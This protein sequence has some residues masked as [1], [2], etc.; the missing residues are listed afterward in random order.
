MGVSPK[1]AKSNMTE[2]KI[3]ELLGIRAFR[4]A[5]MSFERLRHKKDGRRNANYH[6]KNHSLSAARSF[7]WY[8]IYNSIF[9]VLSLLLAA[10]Y[11]V[12]TR[13]F[14]E[15]FLAADIVISVLIVFNVYC[16]MLQRYT[17]IRLKEHIKLLERRRN[18]KTS[19]T[20][21]LLEDTVSERAE[22]QAAAEFNLI[23][24][25]LHA[26]ANGEDLMLSTDDVPALLGIS[27]VMSNARKHKE[28]SDRSFADEGEF[29]TILSELPARV[30]VTDK[31]ERRVSAMQ[32]IIGVPRRQNVLFTFS[33]TTQEA[34]C[35]R[36]Y[37]DIFSRADRDE[38]DV[39]LDSL[40]RAYNKRM[41]RGGGDG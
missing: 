37:V 8:V 16:L 27:E 32:K 24:K 35:E 20:S 36:I 30:Y 22:T 9:H 6:L 41:G 11:F 3:Y 25:M 5:I 14:G 29:D 31:T 15:I 33:V 40:Y 21:S 38:V 34:E 10:V 2:R 13:V 1:N 18:R 12:I 17:W 4:K 28:R 7:R 19:D 23:S 39:I 26:A